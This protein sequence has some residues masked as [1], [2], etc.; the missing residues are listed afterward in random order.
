MSSNCKRVA[1]SAMGI[2]CW[3]ISNAA[4][5]VSPNVK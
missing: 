3:V 2:F 4:R 1:K 5:F